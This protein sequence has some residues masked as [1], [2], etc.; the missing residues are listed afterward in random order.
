MPL[1]SL[2]RV[3]VSGPLYGHENPKVAI[4]TAYANVLIH[5]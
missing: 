3:Y 5:S 4:P 1:E 2:R